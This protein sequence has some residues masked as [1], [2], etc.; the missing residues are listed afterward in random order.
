MK[1]LLTLVLAALLLSVTKTSAQQNDFTLKTDK[2]TISINAG[3][4]AIISINFIIKNGFD[5]SIFLSINTQIPAYLSGSVVN[6][7]Y[8]G[9]KLTIKTNKT[10]TK[11]GLYGI[12]I[13]G[14]NGQKTSSITCYVNVLKDSTNWRIF[15]LGYSMPGYVVQDSQGN[16]W[17]NRLTIEG[18]TQGLFEQMKNIPIEEWTPHQTYK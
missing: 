6:I 2:D 12:V 8:T 17:H 18:N 15:P 5:A 10:F 3:D 9:V 1:T 7:P 16:Y 4:S 13:T 14:T 11:P